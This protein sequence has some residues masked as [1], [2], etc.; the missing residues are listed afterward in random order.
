MRRW[1]VLC[2]VALMIP[3]ASPLA[4]AQANSARVSGLATDAKGL[5]LPGVRITLTETSTGLERVTTTT[6]SGTYSFPSLDPGPYVIQANVQGFSQQ[7]RNF[8]LEVNQVLRLDWTMSVGVVNQSVQVVAGVETLRTSDATLGEVIEPTLVHELP[9]NGRHI[10]DLALLAAGAHQ[11]F[12]AQSGGTNPLYWRPQENSALSV[13]GGR[14]NANYFLLDGSTDTDPT[15]GSQALS[16][17][18]DAVQEF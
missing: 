15:F 7:V 2:A 8:Q 11:G 4:R 14:P 3:M 13:G 5:P 10:L 12:G 9:L 16:P 6:S 17:S 1:L 18:V